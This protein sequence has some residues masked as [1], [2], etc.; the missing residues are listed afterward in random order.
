MIEISPVGAWKR[1]YKGFHIWIPKRLWTWTDSVFLMLIYLG[2]ALQSHKKIL[3]Q[4]GGWDGRPEHGPP[5][6]TVTEQSFAQQ[7]LYPPLLVGFLVITQVS[8][9][10]LGY[11]LTTFWSPITPFISKQ[12]QLSQGPECWTMVRW[13]WVPG[14]CLLLA[15]PCPLDTLHPALLSGPH[16]ALETLVPEGF[17][18][19]G[20]WR[21]SKGEWG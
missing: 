12:K 4:K 17:K 7:N 1:F 2:S 6:R 3:W 9:F 11:L 14:W 16:R 8:L 5:Q 15:S 13:C 18:Q 20:A 21:P 10:V 19:W